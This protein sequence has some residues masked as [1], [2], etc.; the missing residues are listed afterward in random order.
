MSASPTPA[1]HDASAILAWE[2]ECAEVKGTM[3][4]YENQMMTSVRRIEQHEE[5][6]KK[7]HKKKKTHHQKERQVASKKRGNPPRE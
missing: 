2:K 5:D 6:V 1:Q 7:D 4:R 3:D